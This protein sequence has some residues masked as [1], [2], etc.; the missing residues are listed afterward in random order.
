MS[1]RVVARVRPLLKSELDKDTIV[2]A[3]SCD[4]TKQPTIIRIPNP[5]NG[6]ESFS[7][8]FNSVYD[9]QATQ[10]DLFDNEGREIMSFASI[11]P[12][13]TIAQS[14]RPSSTSSMALI[15]R[16]SLMALLAQARHTQCEEGR[17]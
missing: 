3:A 14:P 10:Q 2:E 1:V 12:A 16:F 4:P 5:K 17:A 8:N 9:Q 13:D 11:R 6:A 15:S 7:F